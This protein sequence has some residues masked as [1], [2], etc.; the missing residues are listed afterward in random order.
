MGD[1]LFSFDFDRNMSRKLQLGGI[2]NFSATFA[3]RKNFVNKCR[4]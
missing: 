4:I 2:R 1:V 3:E